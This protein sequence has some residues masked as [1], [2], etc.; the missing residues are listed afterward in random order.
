MVK[1][2]CNKCI[3]YYGQDLS[4]FWMEDHIIKPEKDAG[5]GLGKNAGFSKIAVYPPNRF[6]GTN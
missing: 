1:D 6:L 3:D 5:A 4:H 2:A